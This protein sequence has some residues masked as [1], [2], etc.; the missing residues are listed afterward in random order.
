MLLMLSLEMSTVFPK[1]EVFDFEHNE[2]KEESHSE[3]QKVFGFEHVDNAKKKEK[4]QISNFG[5]HDSKQLGEDKKK[6]QD[7]FISKLIAVENET[8]SLSNKI[9]AV[10]KNYEKEA[11]SIIEVFSFN[12][13][14]QP[15][16][17]PSLLGGTPVN[18]LDKKGFEIVQNCLVGNDYSYLSLLNGLWS[19]YEQQ[20]KELGEDISTYP[21][22]KDSVAI[23]LYKQVAAHC[24]TLLKIRFAAFSLSTFF[25]SGAQY[26]LTTELPAVDAIMNQ[27]QRVF[28]THFSVVKTMKG[29]DVKGLSDTY[30]SIYTSYAEQRGKMCAQFAL[31]LTGSLAARYQPSLALS[32]PLT[33]I[34]GCSL[35]SFELF[36]ILSS[37]EQ[38]YAAGKAALNLFN[39]IVPTPSFSTYQNPS[40]ALQALNSN[41]ASFYLYCALI[42]Q[43]VITGLARSKTALSY[44]NQI[45]GIQ[46][47]PQEQSSFCAFIAEI[48]NPIKTYYKKVAQYYGEQSNIENYTIYSQV[49]SYLTAGMSYWNRAE[50][51]LAQND[52]SGAIAAYQ[53][54]ANCFRNGGNNDLASVLI[55]RTDSVALSNYQILLQSYSQYYQVNTPGNISSFV[56]QMTTP[57]SGT[58]TT[59]Q[60][61]SWHNDYPNGFVQLFYYDAFQ[62]KTSFA[63]AF[64]GIGW[65]AGQALP[66]F[67][68]ML[69]AYQTDNSSTGLII[70]RYLQN[71]LVI[72]ENL[73]QAAECMFYNT[74]L[75]SSKEK[76]NLGV[77][78]QSMA[79][80][81]N[82]G[83]GT[84]QGVVEGALQ[85]L[86]IY[87]GFLNID[88]VLAEPVTA[89]NSMN[90]ALQLPFQGFFSGTTISG[91]APFCIL[92]QIYWSLMNSDACLE[93]L[94]QYPQFTQTIVSS[95]LI[96]AI[97]A[98]E[99]CND[100]SLIGVFTPAYTTAI[101]QKITML[102]HNQ[103]EGSTGLSLLIAEGHALRGR[104]K[105]SLEYESAL[106]CYGAASL[107]G[108]VSAQE[109]YFET[110]DAYAQWYLS[111]S[112]TE[113]ASLYA[114]ALYY[115]GYLAEQ[116]GWKNRSE[117]LKK[118]QTQ[119]QKFSQKLAAD[120]QDFSALVQAGSYDQAIKQ[121]QKFVTLQ[122]AMQVMMIHQKREQL[123]FALT[124]T[125]V[126]D[127]ISLIKTSVAGNAESIKGQV[128]LLLQ[129]VTQT[130]I[131]CSFPLA[132][133][134]KCLPMVDPLANSA[135][136][137]FAHGTEL[138][139]KLKLQFL[140]GNY[141][142]SLQETY[143]TIIQNFTKAI[144]F[145]GKSNHSQ[146]ISKVQQALTDGV[147]FTYFSSVIPSDS[148]ISTLKKYTALQPSFS[149]HFIT[150]QTKGD[151]AA[152]L[153]KARKTEVFNFVE[154]ES[155]LV[156]E[157]KTLEVFGFMRKPSKDLSDHKP[158]IQD[159]NPFIPLATKR[160]ESSK[161]SIQKKFDEGIKES[162][163]FGKDPDYLLRYSEEDLTIKA[164][165][166]KQLALLL[167]AIERTA[168]GPSGLTYQ[169]LLAQ[170]KIMLGTQK[171][172]SSSLSDSSLVEKIVVPLYKKFLS[173]N[174]YNNDFL[175]LDQEV[176][177]YRKQ[178]MHLVTEG[179]D[180]GKA[181]LYTV[182]TLKSKMMPDGTD[183]LVLTTVN[184]PLQAV[185]RFQGEYQTALYYY[186]EYG[187]FYAYTPQLVQVGG[188]SFFQLSDQKFT[189]QAEAFKGVIGAYFGQMK[190]Y[191]EVV[192]N[193]MKNG[194]PLMTMTEK[195]ESLL[196]SYSSTYQMLTNAWLWL[197]SSLEAI[198]TVQQN[199]GI[200]WVST[201]SFNALNLD[202]YMRYMNNKGQFLVGYPLNAAYKQILTDISVLATMALNYAQSPVDQAMLS[203]MVGLAYE[204]SADLLFSYG[205]QAPVENGYPSTGLT[206]L[207]IAELNFTVKYPQCA[208]PIKKSAQTPQTLSVPWGNYF[209]SSNFYSQA[210]TEYQSACEAQQTSTEVFLMQDTDYRKAWGKYNNFLA[211]AITQRLALFGRNALRAKL[212]TNQSGTSFTI[213][214]SDY[215]KKVIAQGRTDGGFVA[216]KGFAALGG[217][218]LEVTNSATIQSQYMIMKNL[219]LDAF[220]YCSAA[221]SVTQAQ[222]SN[223][224]D[225]QLDAGVTLLGK[226][227]KCAFSY[228]IP[229]FEVIKAQNVN[230]TS[231]ERSML[232]I[233]LPDNEVALDTLGTFAIKQLVYMNTFPALI[234]Y[235]LS[236]LMGS[237]NDPAG[238]FYKLKNPENVCALNNFFSQ[239]YGMLVVLYSESFLPT[240][241]Q[242]NPEKLGIDIQAAIQ[243]QE[244]GMIVNA[245][246]YVG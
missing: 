127:F 188:V 82:L 112:S 75:A 208:I 125:P 69:N 8:V 178:V 192:K 155:P 210:Y 46:G 159:K 240:S 5:F 119:L 214:K 172:I 35:R 135:Q 139:S 18:I 83:S 86:K 232:V 25:Q 59:K 180:C 158:I 230:G 97:Q 245:E 237:E 41:M 33:D 63:P 52:F 29:I 205:Q 199:Q 157:K 71:S 243:A 212:K 128:P 226:I 100:P 58:I 77:S 195:K 116:K 32:Q 122:D 17:P 138:F 181:H 95:A 30:S 47:I 164:Q 202:R 66:V 91:F 235:C 200:F 186:T 107:A 42:G 206:N 196:E 154:P 241:D 90:G 171:T 31:S 88:T 149:G 105:T 204:D 233:A 73:V 19:L 169:D 136:I 68:R 24:I 225:A 12:K 4:P 197:L 1:L 236:C 218:V 142:V 48:I 177:R 129:D 11:H 133:M 38:F 49:D 126:S 209:E 162:P 13:P 217:G 36:D 85:Y 118:L 153:Q 179:M 54:A 168:K 166:E 101:S 198:Q 182:Y 56:V 62:N 60:V 207:P 70:K 222:L 16:I 114:A 27:V 175:T 80:H 93:R 156:H 143:D 183:H 152:A 108:E 221:Q 28:D 64:K 189:H 98:Q 6:E 40:L 213:D 130:S 146:M 185:P 44:Q 176:D 106:A 224:T 94:Q 14:E 120:I 10:F 140:S 104:A 231:V 3:T 194:P 89:S 9:G 147:A 193:C 223:A 163:I 246:S 144:D 20:G 53:V 45:I 110:L 111:S 132:Q 238:P 81:E 92:V 228:Y 148:I 170:A 15:T 201:D 211:H 51:C 39:Q 151:I 187:R 203:R 244:Q 2:P 117:L 96:L 99:L 34:C 184:G 173:S 242:N 137:Y 67:S 239:L 161:I 160:P 215:F 78:S 23:M 227:L 102:L 65:L 123:Y 55:R 167:P 61:Y 26:F 191:E 43:N 124:G 134:V 145:F 57:L 121:V 72:L 103:Y 150:A 21:F 87:K 7:E 50:S 74:A 109:N 115:R 174:G 131:V 141:S 79:A 216:E 22:F 84:V 37:L 229:G 234:E 219:L 113:Y 190:R 220:M 76:Q 165:E